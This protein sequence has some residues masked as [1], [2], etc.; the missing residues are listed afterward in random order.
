[1]A[2]INK[3]L[4]ILIPIFTHHILGVSPFPHTY[5][6][7][8]TSEPSDVTEKYHGCTVRN[9]SFMHSTDRIS[10]VCD[11]IKC[12]IIADLLEYSKGVE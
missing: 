12:C 6:K 10:N 7:K 4:N 11:L 1:M 8:M 2:I 3:G 9:I 5:M